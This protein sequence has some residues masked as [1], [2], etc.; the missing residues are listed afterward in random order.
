MERDERLLKLGSRSGL[1]RNGLKFPRRGPESIFGFGAPVD[2]LT[3]PQS[4]CWTAMSSF[5]SRKSRSSL[6]WAIGAESIRIRIR[7]AY[8]FRCVAPDPTCVPSALSYRPRPAVDMCRTRRAICH[9]DSARSTGIAPLRPDKRPPPGRQKVHGHYRALPAEGSFLNALPPKSA[10]PRKRATKCRPP[11]RS[12]CLCD[13]ER[14]RTVD[15][16]SQIFII[17]GGE[18]LDHRPRR[19]S[20]SRDLWPVI[21]K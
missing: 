8:G 6:H 11:R 18:M 10:T 19:P 17:S 15:R 13:N 1:P 21:K 16:I 3:V 9:R 20:R 2:P 5:R 14:K 7:C 4:F 12:H